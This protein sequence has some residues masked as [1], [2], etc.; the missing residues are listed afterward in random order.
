[1]D[2]DFRLKSHNAII[3]IRNKAFWLL[4]SEGSEGPRGCAV[5]FIFLETLLLHFLI[6]KK[7][8]YS[9]FVLDGTFKRSFF[10]FPNSQIVEE[11]Y[12]PIIT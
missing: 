9:K 1:M 7:V 2:L 11:L 12:I 10:Y 8:R 6:K 4:D 5:M 3:D